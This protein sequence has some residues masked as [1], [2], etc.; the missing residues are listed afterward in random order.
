ML[1]LYVGRGYDLVKAN[2][3]ADKIDPGFRAGTMKYTFD[4]KRRHKMESIW[5]QAKLLYMTALLA[6]SMQLPL[7]TQ[8]C[9]P[10]SPSLTILHL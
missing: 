1:P 6:P 8:E 9:P 3:T 4:K 5:F 10:T 7:N 2:P